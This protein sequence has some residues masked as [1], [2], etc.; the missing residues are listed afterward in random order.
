MAKI[1]E[2]M[3]FR[4][5]TDELEISELMDFLQKQTDIHF[6]VKEFGKSNREHIHACLVLKCAKTTFVDRLKKQFSVI[7]GNK[8]Y[9]LGKLKKD[10]DTNARYCYKGKANDYPDIVYTIH[11]ESTWKKYYTDYWE[12]WKQSHPVVPKELLVK[13]EKT[14]TFQM[15]LLDEI[16]DDY[17]DL[18]RCI[19][20]HKGYK[21]H[22]IAQKIDIEKCQDHLGEILLMRLGKCAKNIDKF[23]FERM[24]KGLWFGIIAHCPQNLIKNEAPHFIDNFRNTL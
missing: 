9:G 6:V 5:H 12:Q 2:F 8:Y 1:G 16:L 11:D 14:K 18:V 22:E 19:W 3:H 4:V 23:I 13:K 21:G 15:K 7:K 10:Y 20:F 17:E 24:Y